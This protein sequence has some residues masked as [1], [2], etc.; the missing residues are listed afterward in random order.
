MRELVDQRRPFCRR[1]I[2]R[3]QPHRPFS[4][5]GVARPFIDDNADRSWLELQAGCMLHR[6]D[7]T[8]PLSIPDRLVLAGGLREASRVGSDIQPQ[9]PF[10]PGNY[11]RK[12]QEECDHRVS[13][14]SVSHF[15]SVSSSN[16]ILNVA[17]CHPTATRRWPGPFPP[18][19]GRMRISTS[20]PRAVSRRLSRSIE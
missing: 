13:Y 6:F 4:I 15:S 20:L 16:R 17:L 10:L 3:A 1:W 7:D 18:R 8:W 12:A 9:R 2:A 11:D 14:H 19:L 5:A